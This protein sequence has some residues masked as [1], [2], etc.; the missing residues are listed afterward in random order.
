MDPRAGLQV[1][2]DREILLSPETN[3]DRSVGSSSPV[4]VRLL[5]CKCSVD[6]VPSLLTVSGMS[7]DEGSS[8]RRKTM[9]CLVRMVQERQRKTILGLSVA[10]KGEL[11]SAAQFYEPKLTEE[12]HDVPITATVEP[13]K[14]P[15]HKVTVSFIRH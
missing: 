14:C 2:M 7:I 4:A 6:N 13:A 11:Q 10:R 8:A 15:F 9:M 3:D 1:L 5:Q 12:R